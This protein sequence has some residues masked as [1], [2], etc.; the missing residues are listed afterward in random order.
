[1]D[2]GFK[3][4]GKDFS[5]YNYMTALYDAFFL[6]SSLDLKNS[7][8]AKNLILELGGITIMHLKPIDGIL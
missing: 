7:P 5:I 8:S 6:L 2:K 3:L 4:G 1:M